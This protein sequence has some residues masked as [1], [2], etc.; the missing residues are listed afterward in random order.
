MFLPDPESGRIRLSGGALA[1][2][3]VWRSAENALPCHF[4]KGAEGA[5]GVEPPGPT[6]T[7]TA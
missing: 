5:L 1:P 3:G 7:T 4:E 6:L 2:G